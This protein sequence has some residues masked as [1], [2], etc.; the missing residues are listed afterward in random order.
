MNWN[1]RRRLGLA[2]LFA[3]VLAW[4]VP[5]GA[6]D[7]AGRIDAYLKPFVEG[8]N[9]IGVI[10]VSRGG[11]ALF[12]KGYGLANYELNVPNGPE[13]RFHIASVSKAFTAAAIL[14][15]EERG[16]LTV[17]DPV[18]AYIPGYPGGD[19]IR[20]EH[21]LT[22]SSGIPNVNNFPEYDKESSFHHSVPEI[23][24][25]FRAKPLEFEP[26]ADHRYSNSNYNLLALI[27]EAVSGQS[28]G[29]FL[30]AN[31][32]E[33]LGLGSTA[34]DGD[35]S[36]LI[37]RRATGMEPRGLRDLKLAPRIDWSIKTGN[38]SLVTTASDLAKFACAVFEGRL[39]K[40]ASLI[41]I[42]QAGPVFPYGWTDR[43]RSGRK[44]KGAGG[45]SPG[46]VSNVDYVLADG[47]CIV[48]LS[49]SYSPVT[50]D[51]IAPAIEAIVAGEKTRTEPAAPIPPRAGELA[52][53]A[54]RYQ[55]PEDYYVPG[56]ILT[57][58]NRGEYL[59]AQWGNSDSTIIFP[60]GEGRYLDRSYWAR[61]SF[62]RD[63]GG[64]V[65]GLICSMGRDFKARRL[66]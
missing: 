41:K 14:L 58:V 52:A 39:L 37:A 60:V 45:R 4:A 11:R 64:K 62:T 23:V 13:T 56:V 54:G 17:S 15:L 40:P 2:I 49:N 34:H 6:Q 35:A 30:Q 47:T 65:T 36:A 24:D 27:I 1:M 33:P 25:L 32:F 44:L 7:L 3:V 57:I 9:F 59:E 8:N 21:L 18:S 10:H 61:V 16:K 38:G 50:Q 20:L 43:V 26:G 31:I 63:E 55:M 66:S 12:Q 29:A 28:Y 53:L 42:K 22:H 5:M 48:I 51:P 19:K 46:F